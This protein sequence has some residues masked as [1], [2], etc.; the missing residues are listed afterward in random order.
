M[1]FKTYIIFLLLLGVLPDVYLF[2]KVLP[3]IPLAARLTVFLPTLVELACLPLIGTGVRYTDTV[4][5]FSYV[6]FLFELPKSIVALL[7]IM[8]R[9][10]PGLGP[11]LADWVAFGVGACVSL[12]FFVLIFFMTRHLKVHPLELSFDNLPRPFDGM[13]ICQMSDLH[14][15]SFGK[16][17]RYVQRIVDT[18]VSNAP[19]VIFFTGDLVNFSSKEADPYLDELSQLHAPL[20]IFA[21]RGNHDYLLH[22]HHSGEAR[23]RD[24]ERLLEVERG[25]GWHILLNESVVLEK[26]G[27]RM[28]VMGVENYSSNPFFKQVKGDLKAALEGLPEGIFKIL[29]SHDP[30]HW[31]AEVLSESDISLTLSGH[32]HGLKYKLAGLRPSHWKLPESSGIYRLRDRVLHVSE[33]LGSAFAFR[34]GG[35]PKIDLITLHR[36]P[37]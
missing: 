33:G 36:K 27:A 17:A 14:L 6:G 23:V 15:G 26:D 8:G 28:A 19:D 13:R 32:T 29:L 12:L 37:E 24:M 3:D 10:L 7:S 4:R 34:V 20:G 9:L 31:R 18:V 11:A 5:V 16:K 35:F 2:L 1:K 22:G 30:S 25:L 21:I